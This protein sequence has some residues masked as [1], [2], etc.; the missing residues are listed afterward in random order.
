MQIVLVRAQDD[1]RATAFQDFLRSQGCSCH[2]S[3]LDNEKLPALTESSA[4]GI[5][6]FENPGQSALEWISRAREQTRYLSMPLVVIRAADS[7]E[8]ESRLIA[9]GAAAVC[10]PQIAPD[11]LLAEVRAHCISQ[12]VIAEVREKL[13]GPFTEATVLTMRE[14]AGIEIAV[15]S[16]YQKTGYRMFGDISAVLGL[17]GKAEGSLVISFPERTAQ[18]FVGRIL[19]SVD[20]AP[21]PSIVRDCIGELSNVIA[22]QARGLLADSAYQFS[23]S[24]PTVISGA[25]HE[26]RHKPGA[27][28]LVVAFGCDL[29]EFA[30]QL[31]MSV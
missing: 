21:G 26:I 29:G 28:C 7:H 20:A 25:N 23:L 1:T 31:C 3:A 22:G 17:L 5:V 14:M 24:I 9:A 16:V 13:L 12:P 2:A 8:F 30:L 4:C 19:A 27:P 15:R 18:A 11:Q 6:V 10:P